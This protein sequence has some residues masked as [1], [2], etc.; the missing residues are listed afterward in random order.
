MDDYD[1]LQDRL[2]ELMDIRQKLDRLNER[3]E[4]MDVEWDDLDNEIERCRY[5]MG[6]IE[7]AEREALRREYERSLMYA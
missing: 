3:M 2:D 4:E 5:Q 1:S 6:A 7:E